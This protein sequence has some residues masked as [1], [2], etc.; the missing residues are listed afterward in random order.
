MSDGPPG[1]RILP[2][3]DDRDPPSLNIFRTLAKNRPLAKGFLSLGGHLLGGNVLPS[4]E[5]EIVILRVG[6]RANSEYEFGQHTT[7]GLAAG[8]SQAEIG[9]LTVDGCNGWSTDDAALIRLVDELCDSDVVGQET[10]TALA[11]RWSESELLE[12]L[13]LAGFYRLV[14]GMLNSVGVALEAK[15]PGWPA[16]VADRRAA[17]REASA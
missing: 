15:T 7:I 5:R 10:W 3:D 9:R 6:W 2:L 12:L 14:S 8:L 13:V 16:S 11:S 1:P 4:R 17:S